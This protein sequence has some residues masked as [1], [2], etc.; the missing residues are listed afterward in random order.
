MEEKKKYCS[1]KD[2]KEIE[3]I[4][5]CSRCQIYMCNKCLNYHEGFYDDHPVTKIKKKEKEI[6]TGYC[7]EKNHINK[8]EYFCKNHNQLCCGL[9]ICKIKGE[10]KGQHK[11]CDVC[12]IKDIKE[13]KQ[14]KLKENIKT[15]EELSKDLD[16]V[17]KEL[18]DI[19]EKVNERKE[20]LIMDIQKVFTNIRNELN[21]KE[22]SL[23]LEVQKYFDD[24][25]YVEDIMKKSEKLPKKVNLS[26]EKGKLIENEWN[27]HKLIL[28][29]HNCIN[30]ENDLK[31][32][33]IINKKVKKYK[34]YNKVD[35]K[36]IYGDDTIINNLKNYLFISNINYGSLILKEEE[37]KEKFNKLINLKI[38]KME[39][40][41]RAS[42]DGL[43]YSN[44]VNKINNKSNLIFLYLTGKDRIFGAFIQTKLTDIDMDGSRKYYTDENA[45]V[46]S[47]NLNK[48]YQILVPQN[49]I[50]FDDSDYILIGNNRNNNGFWFSG[51][52]IY[53]K[54][55]IKVSK[56][57]HFNKNSELTEG[58]GKLI[59]LEIFKLS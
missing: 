54:D 44:I 29:I 50:G 26:L 13:Q 52:D 33:N 41:Y 23:L 27:K 34:D 30:I 22:D 40:L 53:D 48:K 16:K 19:F 57:Y 9:C 7:K 51:K 28:L 14:K 12:F 37:D 47:L 11:D 17:I 58:N 20:K 31:D 25:Y 42:R 21:K 6:F 15:L 24:N 18:K 39:L 46:F 32:I 59:E 8:L 4:S 45:F 3:A 56:I 43:S 10:G 2:H 49:A 1:F 38:N 5:Y 36:F 55:L 35:I